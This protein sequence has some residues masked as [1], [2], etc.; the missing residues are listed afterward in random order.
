[1]RLDPSASVRW[2]GERHTTIHGGEVVPTIG[3]GLPVDRFD[4]T[5]YRRSFD[6]AGDIVDLDGAV[7][8]GRLD[9]TGYS[10]DVKLP[11]DGHHH[12]PCLGRESNEVFHFSDTP[13]EGAAAWYAGPNLD[14][15]TLAIDLD[16]DGLERALA[17]GGF[18]RLDVDPLLVP[19]LD[20]HGA[21]DVLEPKRPAGLE[22]SR[23]FEAIACRKGRVFQETATECGSGK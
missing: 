17:G 19:G 15:I 9:S 14:Q 8:G 16:L 6:F 12:D 11:I 22:V 2:K 23:F 3:V 1:M 5:V 21:V 7:H 13:E 20:G 4:T 10:T 18:Y